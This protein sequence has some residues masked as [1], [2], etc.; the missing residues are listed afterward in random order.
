MARGLAGF[1]EQRSLGESNDL[2]SKRNEGVGVAS[3]P[4]ASH[5]APT[6]ARTGRCDGQKTSDSSA[7]SIGWS[8]TIHNSFVIWPWSSRTRHQRL[9]KSVAG[10]GHAV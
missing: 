6:S 1:F 7:L 2:R 3:E 5:A 8:A 9:T 4:P 10:R